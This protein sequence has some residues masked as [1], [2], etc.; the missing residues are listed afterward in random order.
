MS[1]S[2]EAIDSDRCEAAR[3]VF[4]SLGERLQTGTVILFD[5]Y[6]GLRGWRLGEWKAGN[7]FAE[8]KKINYDYLELSGSEVVL[9][10]T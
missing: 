3:I 6:F 10:I 8:S 4:E 7:E 9:K 2:L 1:N 5:E